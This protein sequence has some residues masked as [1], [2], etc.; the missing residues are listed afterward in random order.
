MPP[1]GCALVGPN[2]HGKTNLLEAI[3]YPV[4][5][6]SFRGAA[7]SELVAQG[8]AEFQ[9][10]LAV[11]EGPLASVEAHFAAQGRQKRVQLDGVEEARLTAAIGRWLAVFFQPADV[12]LSGG[13]AAERRRYLDRM[14]S[15]ADPAYLKALLRFRAALAQRNAALRQRQPEVAAAFEGLL[16]ST[17]AVIVRRR[18]DWVANEGAG[19]A[20]EVAALGERQGAGLAYRGSTELADPGSWREAFAAAAARDRARGST[21]VG[22]HRH[23]LDLQV[24]GRALRTWGSTGQVRT[25]AI[26]LKLAE[27]ETLRRACGQEPVLLLD[28][29]FAELDG[30]RQERLA[31]R[32]HAPARQVFVTAPRADELPTGF[33]LPRWRMDS[34]RAMPGS[35]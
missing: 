20:A 35:T 13:P 8:Q 29:A 32:L 25:A 19:F 28:D 31:H 23:D 17:G 34:G 2:G 18:L 14:L 4:L 26:A 15:L 6:R 30:D 22:P 3:S 21:S 24:E 33:D 5:F 1:G 7:D 27:L 11:A 12:A 10:S 9:L 16:A